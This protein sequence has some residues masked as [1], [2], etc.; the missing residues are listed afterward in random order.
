MNT[1][2][3]NNRRGI[4]YKEQFKQLVWA[5]IWE[6]LNPLNSGEGSEGTINVTGPVVENIAEELK[7]LFLPLI[8]A[9]ESIEEPAAAYSKDQKVFMERVISVCQGTATT[10]ME[11][12]TAKM[13]VI[14]KEHQAAL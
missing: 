5:L 7:D 4:D 6:H 14:I 8:I 11:G 10:A 3:K 13:D 9:L 1:E 2:F 12:I